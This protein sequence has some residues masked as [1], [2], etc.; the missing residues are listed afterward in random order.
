MKGNSPMTEIHE[1]QGQIT[2]LNTVVAATMLPI[3]T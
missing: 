2:E 3:E 1:L